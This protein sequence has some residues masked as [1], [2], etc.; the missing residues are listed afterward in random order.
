I[1]FTVTQ[2]ECRHKTAGLDLLRIVYPAP[3]VLRAVLD[4]ARGQCLA[5]HEVRQVRSVA[6]LR[7]RAT[8]PVAVDTGLGKERRLAGD[9]GRIL[10]RRLSFVLNPTLKFAGRIDNDANK[11]VG[12]LR[13]AVLSALPKVEPGLVRLEPHTVDAAWDEVGLAGQPGRPKA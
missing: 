8:H 9:G 11:H 3:E 6:A 1:A 4:H 7:G 12:V 13:A 5:R 10:D 2:A